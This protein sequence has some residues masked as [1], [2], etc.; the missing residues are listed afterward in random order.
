MHT[1]QDT[2]A[3]TR[4]QKQTH[5]HS[6]TQKQVWAPQNETNLRFAQLLHISDTMIER[7]ALLHR[8][9]ND[10]GSD[11]NQETGY[12]DWQFSSFPLF[13]HKNSGIL[14]SGLQARTVTLHIMFQS[15]LTNT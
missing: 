3:H 8:S 4:A 15:L 7:L 5:T 6:R 14:P 1:R 13:L 2:Q 11:L 12:A 9:R 10:L